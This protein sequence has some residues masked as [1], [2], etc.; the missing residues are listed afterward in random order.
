MQIRTVPGG[1]WHRRHS[2]DESRTA[3]GEVIGGAFQ[4][5]DDELDDQICAAC[6][7]RDERDT[8]KMKKIALDL[9]RE[10]DPIL[11]F[12]PDDEPTDPNG[13]EET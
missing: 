9:E 10:S 8:G 5:R 7:T 3:C 6:F 12:D 1:P 4:T 11:F 2:L 13:G